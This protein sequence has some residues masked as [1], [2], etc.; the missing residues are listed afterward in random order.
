VALELEHACAR[1]WLSLAAGHQGR[2]ASIGSSCR[3]GNPDSTV[4]RPSTV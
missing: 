4:L 3:I 1:L 2:W